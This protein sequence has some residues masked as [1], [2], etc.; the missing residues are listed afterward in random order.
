[1]L[2]SKRIFFY[3]SHSRDFVCFHYVDAVPNQYLY[4]S[5]RRARTRITENSE[6][7]WTWEPNIRTK[8]QKCHKKKPEQRS[9]PFSV[10]VPDVCLAIYNNQDRSVVLGWQNQIV[11]TS[12]AVFVVCPCPTTSP[13]MLGH[14]ATAQHRCRRKEQTKNGQSGYMLVNRLRILSHRSSLR[15]LTSAEHCSGRVRVRDAT[16]RITRPLTVAR[17]CRHIAFNVFNY[18]HRHTQ[19]HMVQGTTWHIPTALAAW[20]F[21]PHHRRLHKMAQIFKVK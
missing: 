3:G 7:I 13:Y 5:G 8:T 20:Q 12:T 14:A 11:N 2:T 15:I 17:A 16:R 9:T 18:M 4:S 10:W 19:A 1:M 21:Q 6:N